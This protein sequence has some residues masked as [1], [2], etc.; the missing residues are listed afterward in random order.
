VLISINKKWGKS[1]YISPL[2]IN[3]NHNQ[4]TNF[5]DWF[6][7]ML[8]HTPQECMEQFTA[9]TY[10]IWYSRNQKVFQGKDLPAN[11]ICSTALNQLAEF[12]RLNLEVRPLSRDP[13]TVSSS[14]NTSWS[15]PPRGTLK[16]NVD[17]HLSSDG[18][19]F[20]GL[21][22]RRSDGSTVG[23]ATRSHFELENANF[24]EALGLNDAL[25]MVERMQEYSVI[26]ELDSQVVV[27]AI[28]SP[29]LIRK[30]WGFIAR[31]CKSFLLSHPNSSI[32]WVSRAKNQVAH[33]LARW[34]ESEPNKD[35]F[36]SFLDCIKPY[37]QKDISSLYFSS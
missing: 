12:Q 35:W 17:A 33:H 19:W 3:L 20:S 11:D 15:P 32:C 26:F 7:H 18:H 5:Y 24:G 21:L 6:D 13:V 29:D 25:D 22:L 31:R 8:N 36:N 37:I 10:G 27:K 14:H 16:I 2:T 34:A 30:P 1:M 23:A 28:S 4:F 9:I